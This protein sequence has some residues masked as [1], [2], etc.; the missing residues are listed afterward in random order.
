MAKINVTGNAVVITSTVKFEDIAKAKKY[1]PDALILCEEKGGELT[2][3]FGVDVGREAKWNEYGITFNGK[4][5][6]D[7]FATLT[8]LIPTIEE[9]LEEAIADLYGAVILKLNK[10]EEKF[11]AALEEIKAEREKVLG[12]I[13]IQ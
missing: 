2:P 10:F 1:R 6:N 12:T 5:H 9:G 8:E 11:P 13:S 4:T 3:V 7:G